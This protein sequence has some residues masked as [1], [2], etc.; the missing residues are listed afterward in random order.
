MISM[1]K[2]KRI[3]VPLDGTPCSENILPKVERLAS[4]LGTGIC[5]LRVV[6]ARTFPGA[7]PTE[8]QI[9]VVKEAE[10]YLRKI[11]GQLK[12]KGLDADSH[13]RYGDEVEEILD[14]ATKEEV[15]LIAMS[16]HG[17]T[18]IKRWLL[19]SAAEKIVENSPRPVFVARCA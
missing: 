12:A 14:H 7:D 19:G 2:Q 18:G 5:L 4:D 17:R 16:T 15:D 10:E 3:M 13:V 11:E 8:A 1:E 6:H 9:S